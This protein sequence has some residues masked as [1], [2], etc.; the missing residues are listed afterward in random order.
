MIKIAELAIWFAKHKYEIFFLRSGC[1]AMTSGSFFGNY[2]ILSSDPYFSNFQYFSAKIS[3]LT[4][5]I[6]SQFNIWDI[7][8]VIH[9]IWTGYIIF[10]QKRPFLN[11]YQNYSYQGL[12]TKA[13]VKSSQLKFRKPNDR[14]LVSFSSTPPR[15]LLPSFQIN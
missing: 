15:Y 10:F 14:C 6:Y 7:H 8:N 2:V 9:E 13:S 3:V 4:F 5:S 12:A 1:F 11:S